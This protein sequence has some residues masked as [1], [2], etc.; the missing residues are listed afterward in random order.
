MSSQSCWRRMTSLLMTSTSLELYETSRSASSTTQDRMNVKETPLIPVV[1]H[2]SRQLPL[3]TF[4]SFL[5]LSPSRADLARSAMPKACVAHSIHFSV[6]LWLSSE[7]AAQL[8]SRTAVQQTDTDSQGMHN[9]SAAKYYC[10][11]TDYCAA[12]RLH[13]LG[14]A[15]ADPLPVHLSHM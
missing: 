10:P 8:E 14:T 1:S 12:Q 15:K 7:S 2:A 5:G 9:F 3:Q 11:H 13:R 4:S 6:C